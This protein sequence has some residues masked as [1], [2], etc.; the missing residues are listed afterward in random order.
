MAQKKPP[1][2]PAGPRKA[3][4]SIGIRGDRVR[5]ARVAHSWSQFELASRSQ[6]HPSAISQ[7]EKGVKELNAASVVSLAKALDVSADYL[8]GL[9]SEPSRK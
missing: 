8:L 5:S 9:T 3:S 2:S 4:R 1:S 6:V 7:V